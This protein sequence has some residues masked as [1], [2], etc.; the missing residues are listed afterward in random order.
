MMWDI[1]TVLLFLFILRKFLLI[2]TFLIVQD[3]PLYRQAIK[4]LQFLKTS[5]DQ[6]YLLLFMQ[7]DEQRF[8]IRHRLEW[9][10]YL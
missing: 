4:K 1:T 9:L 10:D 7:V 8:Q 3:I 6:I 5:H 2:F